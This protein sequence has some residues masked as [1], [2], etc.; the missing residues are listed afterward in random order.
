MG[1]QG[2]LCSSTGRSAFRVAGCEPEWQ[3]CHGLLLGTH[4]G[5]ASAAGMYDD[6]TALAFNGLSTGC[7]FLLQV[8]AQCAQKMPL[9]CRHLN[10][11]NEETS[12]LGTAHQW[13]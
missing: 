12:A 7:T 1:G 6:I 8:S 11:N 4:A 13:R 10:C 2:P 9:T 5:S 3:D